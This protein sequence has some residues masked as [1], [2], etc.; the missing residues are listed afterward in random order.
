M[1]FDYTECPSIVRL[2]SECIKVNG[3]RFGS[4]HRLVKQAI[5]RGFRAIYEDIAKTM[6]AFFYDYVSRMYHPMM[7][8]IRQV[9]QRGRGTSSIPSQKILL[10]TA[11]AASWNYA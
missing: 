10:N 6:F 11:P 9:R 4:V 7:N 8:P 1:S 2:A 5:N 3:V